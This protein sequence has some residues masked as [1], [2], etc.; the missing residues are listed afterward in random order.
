MKTIL[1]NEAAE[2]IRAA[3]KITFLTGAGVS[4]PSGIPDYRSLKGI[5]QGVEQPEY[6]LSH[7]A[8]VYE[9]EKFYQFVQNIYHPTA[10]PN[11]IHQTMAKLEEQKEVWVVS[12]N[13]DGLHEE[14]GSKH[15]INFHGSLYECS[16]RKCGRS[17]AW[18]NYL[19]SDRHEEEN[20]G[21]QIRPDIVLYGEGFKEH[22]L[23]GAMKAVE[24]AEL[25]VIVGTSFQVHP[26]CDLIR[27][28]QPQA[29]V[30]VINQTPIAL[31]Q[32]HSFVEADGVLVFQQ[33]N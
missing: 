28:K 27:Y 15:V 1:P 2:Q 25:V 20:C 26:F 3:Q 19:K 8:M 14:A 24:Q 12:Q 11:I 21:G 33:I 13:I 18:Q 6:L 4:T 29:Q 10:Q 16:C 17:V 23:E 30:L 9:P 22:V 31:A 32:P 7:E 5:Y